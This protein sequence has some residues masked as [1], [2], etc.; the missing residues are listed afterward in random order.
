MPFEFLRIPLFT[1][2]ERQVKLWAYGASYYSRPQSCLVAESLLLGSSFRSHQVSRPGLTAEGSNATD[3]VAPR[4]FAHSLRWAIGALLFTSTVINYLDRQT[5]SILAPFLKVDFHWTNTEIA[6]RI[7]YSLGQTV[8]GRLIDCV[9]TRRGITM[10]VAAYSVAS[11]LT[12]LARGLHSF[13][14]FR[15][16]LGAGESANWPRPP[17]QC[18]NGFRKRAGAGD[19][20]F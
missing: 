20:T 17:R 1:F 7:D 8:C 5:L 2:A 11:M 13:A 18:P 12:P 4:R 10:T 9:G 15:F 3:A 16:L 19:S 6:F 14:F